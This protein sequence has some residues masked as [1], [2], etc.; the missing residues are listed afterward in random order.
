MLHRYPRGRIRPLLLGVSLAFLA[1]VG[2]SGG[3]SADMASPADL[4]T[5]T[6]VDLAVASNG[7]AGAALLAG[8]VKAKSEHYQVIMSLGEQ[9]AGPGKST[10]AQLRGGVVGATQKK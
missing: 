1:E 6:T 10:N 3:S 2:C 7:H 4:A 9:P 5:S 8:A